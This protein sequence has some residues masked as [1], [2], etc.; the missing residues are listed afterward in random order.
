MNGRKNLLYLVTA[1]SYF[2]T[3]RYKNIKII[4]LN[5]Y[6]NGVNNGSNSGCIKVRILVGF[7]SIYCVAYLKIKRTNND[8]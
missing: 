8:R 6:N 7:Y 3:K 1:R 4:I 2:T 5:Y